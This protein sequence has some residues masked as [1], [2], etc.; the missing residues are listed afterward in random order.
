VESVLL[1][2]QSFTHLLNRQL[3]KHVVFYLT[4]IASAYLRQ[5]SLQV[6]NEQLIRG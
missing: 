6:I 4:P 3:K 2:Y 1:N 5:D